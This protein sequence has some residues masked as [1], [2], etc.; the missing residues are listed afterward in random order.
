[1]GDVV[2]FPDRVAELERERFRVLGYQGLSLG[3][4]DVEALTEEE[5]HAIARD[6]AE[7][8][9]I[10]LLMRDRGLYDVGA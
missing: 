5:M 6:T 7:M 9:R 4:Y 10:G 8:E 1:M 3:G 2:A